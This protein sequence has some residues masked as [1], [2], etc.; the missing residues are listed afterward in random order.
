VVGRVVSSV[1]GGGKASKF[2]Y[3]MAQRLGTGSTVR[4]GFLENATYP[5]ENQTS[6]FIKGVADLEKT[7]RF[8][9]GKGPRVLRAGAFVGPRQ[10]K[11]TTAALHV[12]QVAW[13]NNY[14]TKTSR[15]RPFFTNMI[16]EKSPTWGKTLARVAKK[17]NYD[18]ATTL[19]KM[20]E[21]IEGQLVKAIVDWPADNAPLTIAI[22]GFNKGL[23]DRRIM[24]RS[25][26]YEVLK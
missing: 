1:V 9:Q 16:E 4:V 26:G 3:D 23:V 15:A 11:A 20:G 21:V 6:R 25:T 5:N 10:P 22:K 7:K 8:L 13:W 24:Q 18:G 12:A 14:G 2:L 19:G 17:A